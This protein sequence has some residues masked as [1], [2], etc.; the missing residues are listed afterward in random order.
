[1]GLINAALSLT[2]RLQGETALERK[3][4]DKD[5]PLIAEAAL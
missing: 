3:I 2:K 5:S 1:V 4:P